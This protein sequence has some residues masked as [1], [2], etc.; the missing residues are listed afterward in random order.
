MFARANTHGRKTPAFYANSV[1]QN[2]GW[3]GVAAGV[4]QKTVITK[5][6]SCQRTSLKP[7]SF[8]SLL[9]AGDTLVITSVLGGWGGWSLEIFGVLLCATR[10][11]VHGSPIAFWGL[12]LKCK[13]VR[14]QKTPFFCGGVTDS[15][16]PPFPFTCVLV[17]LRSLLPQNCF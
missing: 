8:K 14:C 9:F 4:N 17:F 13:L 7:R 6:F 1:C 15:D 12:V 16:T 11:A 5:A 10:Q 3:G 2:L